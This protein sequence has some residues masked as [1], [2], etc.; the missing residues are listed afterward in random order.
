ML[1]PS[2]M[3]QVCVASS[4]L[5]TNVFVVGYDGGAKRGASSKVS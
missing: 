3:I 2:F 4:G 5:G 1:H